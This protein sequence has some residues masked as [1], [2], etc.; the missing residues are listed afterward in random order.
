[1]APFPRPRFLGLGSWGT[2]RRRGVNGDRCPGPPG[3]QGRVLRGEACR[4]A[5]GPEAVAGAPGSHGRRAAD[6]SRQDTGRSPV[7]TGLPEA[8]HAQVSH[9]RQPPCRCLLR[10]PST[11]AL[12]GLISQEA[13][14]KAGILRHLPRCPASRPES[15]VPRRPGWTLACS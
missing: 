2:M 13:K 7:T 14:E 6:L 10:L 11:Y 8:S 15:W 1:M 4:R 12:R 9:A 3:A 5:A